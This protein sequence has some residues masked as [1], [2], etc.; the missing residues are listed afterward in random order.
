[1]RQKMTARHDAV[2][3]IH[4]AGALVGMML[5]LI[6]AGCF[7]GDDKELSEAVSDDVDGEMVD[8]NSLENAFANNSNFYGANDNA[9]Y[10]DTYG[11]DSTDS[12]AMDSSGGADYGSTEE[13]YSDMTGGSYAVDPA[14]SSVAGGSVHFVQYDTEV[15]AGPDG[16][17]VLFSLAQGDTVSGEAAGEYT[18]IG[19][20][21]Y[22][23]SAALSQG[24]VA[25]PPVANPWR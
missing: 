2:A 18:M 14:M 7:G 6:I 12:Y 24:I 21:Q 4:G 10:G 20:G 9:S 22:V 19:V 3:A 23:M 5:L 11:N 1:M 15:F 25:R 13:N 17:T 16:A 8:S